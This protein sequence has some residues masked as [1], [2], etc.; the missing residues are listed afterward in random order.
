MKKTHKKILIAVIF[1]IIIGMASYTIFFQSE[2]N[3]VSIVAKALNFNADR[4]SLE[5]HG[6]GDVNDDGQID[7]LDEQLIQ[8][9]LDQSQ[10]LTSEQQS[11]ADI[12][13][14]GEITT[15]D[16]QDLGMFIQEQGNG[17]QNN[18]NPPNPPPGNDGNNNTTPPNPPQGNDGNNN[19]T[20][21][22]P[23]Q[24]NEGDNNTTPPNPP[25]DNQVDTQNIITPQNT[26]DTNNSTSLN[27]IVNTSTTRNT[28]Q[29][30]TSSKSVIPKTGLTS[31]ISIAIVILL[32][33]T[34]FC[35][36]KYKK[37][38]LK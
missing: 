11:R 4:P 26:S 19:T 8:G 34:V 3:N 5:A 14:D 36:Y 13:G 31:T 16:A 25:Q 22:N 33:S 35:I 18:N 20:P 10:P 28:E 9:H 12:N 17:G 29:N 15:K 37:I 30:K 21:P 1:L 24:G 32:I 7:K 27:N 2:I 23:P 6:L 38:K